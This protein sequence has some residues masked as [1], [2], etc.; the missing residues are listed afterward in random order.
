MLQ[1]CYYRS[2]Q[3]TRLVN[4]SRTTCKTLE[5]LRRR[6]NRQNLAQ[7][8]TYLTAMQYSRKLICLHLPLT[9]GGERRDVFGSSVRPSGRASSVSQLTPYI[10]RRDMSSTY[11]V[12]TSEIK[13]KQNKRKTMFCFSEIVLFQFRFSVFTC[14]TKR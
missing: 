4:T 7:P 1:W 10:P 8:L 13:L 5:T 12:V 9:V 11:A 2:Q 3:L 14:E 6:S